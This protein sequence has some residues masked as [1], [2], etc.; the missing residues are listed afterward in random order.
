MIDTKCLE[1]WLYRNGCLAEAEVFSQ[2]TWPSIE[3]CNQEISPLTSGSSTYYPH[4]QT[5]SETKAPEFDAVLNSSASSSSE[6]ARTRR[7]DLE[8][9]METVQR[10]CCKR[11]SCIEWDIPIIPIDTTELIAMKNH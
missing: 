6:L 1:R 10:G 4:G 7:V 11:D 8:G 3:G 9:S 5:Q 2:G